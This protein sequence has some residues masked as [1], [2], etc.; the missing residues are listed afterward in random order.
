MQCEKFTIE[1][2]LYCDSF[3]KTSVHIS[4]YY[5]RFIWLFK[6]KIKQRQHLNHQSTMKTNN[7]SPSSSL[8]FRPFLRKAIIETTKE[9][10]HVTPQLHTR[11]E[12]RAWHF[13]RDDFPEKFKARRKR[14]P[15]NH[16]ALSHCFRIASAFVRGCV[17]FVN[18]RMAFDE[19]HQLMRNRIPRTRDNCQW[20]NCSWTVAGFLCFLL[21]FKPLWSFLK[22]R[23]YCNIFRIHLNVMIRMFTFYVILTFE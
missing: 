13:P 2:S 11:L 6:K 7:K 9:N 16:G 10:H 8:N 22:C 1:S 15:I 3:R 5:K 23:S 12:T 14:S 21:D 17:C 18:P 19:M 4:K 20:R